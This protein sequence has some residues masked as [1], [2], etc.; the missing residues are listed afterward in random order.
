MFL[1]KAVRPVVRD[2]K[3][4]SRI[5]LSFSKISYLHLHRIAYFIE[6]SKVKIMAKEMGSY[7]ILPIIGAK[8]FALYFFRASPR[9]AGKFP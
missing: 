7:N 1:P 9:I 8:G 4:W 3:R 5:N 2:F 6:C